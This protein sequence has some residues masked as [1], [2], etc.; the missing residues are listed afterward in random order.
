[1]SSP[2]FD[3][4]P[5]EK[6]LDAFG[7][8]GGDEIESGNLNSS[9]SSAALAANTFGLFLDRPEDFPPLPGFDTVSWPPIAIEIECQ[10]R[11]PWRGGVHPWLDAFI[12]TTAFDEISV[13]V[14]AG[15]RNHLYRNF[16]ELR[17]T[18]EFE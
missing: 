8:S 14:V 6:L 18:T 13:K 2:F 16:L 17:R 10:V 9:E 3:Y 7:K 1:M 12:E 4:L 11:F 15:T 5:T